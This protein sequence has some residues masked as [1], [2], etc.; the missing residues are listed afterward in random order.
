MDSLGR[1]RSR[2][3]PLPGA[4]PE[5]S[6]G[7]ELA[8]CLRPP[9]GGVRARPDHRLRQALSRNLDASVGKAMAPPAD[10]HYRGEE[11]AGRRSRQYR[12]NHRP[13]LFGGRNAGLRRRAQ[14]A[15]PG[16][17]L[18]LRPRLR[19]AG[20][21]VAG[22][23]L[24]GHCS[25]AHVADAGTLLDRAVSS[26]EADGPNRQ[27]R[28]G[29]DRRRSGPDR[30]SQGQRNRGG[31]ARCLRRGTSAGRESSVAHAE[32]HRLSPHVGGL[33]RLCRRPRQGVPRELSPLLRG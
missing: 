3:P 13:N 15:L 32:R 8:R 12:P 5:Q 22:R 33:L 25:S 14:R 21:S 24:R 30:R 1:R 2:R 29:R 27:R 23:G 26:H 31:G 10:G 17:G 19:V 18:R 7:N 9:D 28:P 16:S 4:G 20:R 11:G 6:Q